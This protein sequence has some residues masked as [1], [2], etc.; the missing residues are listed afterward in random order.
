MFVAFPVLSAAIAADVWHDMPGGKQVH[1][2]CI[3]HFDQPFT[4]LSS[5][6]VHLQNGTTIHHPPCPHKPRSARPSALTAAPAPTP[7]LG[8]YS[9][10]VA[11]AQ[12]AHADGLGY[13]SS[14]FVVPEPPTSRGPAPPLVASSIYLFNGLE[15][16]MGHAGNGSVI[17]QP[18][19]QFGKSGCLTN[20]LK[21]KDWYLT[22]YLVNGA[23]RAYCGANVG[24]LKPGEALRGAMTLLDGDSGNNTWRV[25]STRLSTGEVS[26]TTADMGALVIDA[27][28][29]TLEAMVLYSCAAYP[30]SGSFAFTNNTLLDRRMQPLSAGDDGGH[31]QKMLKKTECAQDV[32]IAG[33]GIADPV[34]ITWSPS[35]DGSQSQ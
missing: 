31:W 26:T 17:L 2:S 6:A 3:H 27:A 5:G 29:L 10:W 13:L 21:H 8:Y 34:T 25:D 14:D 35:S 18:V 15:D 12:A 30:A 23:G 11:Y 4:V 24:P 9:S 7:A 20:P 16:G 28:Y 22:S 1:G 33:P 19:L 32:Q